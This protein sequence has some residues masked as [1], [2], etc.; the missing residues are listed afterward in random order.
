MILTRHYNPSSNTFLTLG[1]TVR[2]K[3]D[4]AV[5][6]QLSN[7]N[8]LVLE[9]SREALSSLFSIETKQHMKSYFEK[10]DDRT[11]PIQLDAEL[12]LLFVKIYETPGLSI[13]NKEKLQISFYENTAYRLCN[14]KPAIDCYIQ[15]LDEQL[16]NVRNKTRKVKT[17]FENYYFTSIHDNKIVRKI[18]KYG[19]FDPT[20]IVQIELIGICA[21]IFIGAI[22][23]E[24]RNEVVDV[25]E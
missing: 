11:L 14:L 7:K 19:D 1:I 5:R 6:V 24:K 18:F 12:E 4:N 20:Y 25:E 15:E 16:E 23:Q 10:K 9:L 3:L 8:G 13:R 2:N 17:I 21:K 22:D